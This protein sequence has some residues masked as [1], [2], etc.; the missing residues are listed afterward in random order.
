MKTLVPS[1]PQ[2]LPKAV[3]HVARPNGGPLC[4]E[5]LVGT[6]TLFMDEVSCASCLVHLDI[7]FE[8]AYAEIDSAGRPWVKWRSDL[9]AVRPKPPRRPRAWADDPELLRM[10]IELGVLPEE[11]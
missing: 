9:I 4:E 1:W 10:L 2:P 3:V 7:V 5:G 11:E 6:S 8:E